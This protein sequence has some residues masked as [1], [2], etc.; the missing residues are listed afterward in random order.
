[1]LGLRAVQSGNARHAE[2]MQGRTSEHQWIHLV[3]TEDILNYFKP[4]FQ[5]FENKSRM[6]NYVIVCQLVKG[7]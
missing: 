1:M 4:G 2:S 7:M 5:K 3:A 6:T